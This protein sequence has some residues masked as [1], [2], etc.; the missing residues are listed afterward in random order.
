MFFDAVISRRLIA[1]LAVFGV[2]AIVVYNLHPADVVQSVIYE[3]LGT[4]AVVSVTLRARRSLGSERLGLMIVAAGIGCWVSGDLLTDVLQY[5]SGSATVSY[6]SVADIPYTL[7]YGVIL[8][9]AVV[10]ARNVLKRPWT[11]AFVDAAI[12][13]STFVVIGWAAINA[14]GASAGSTAASLGVLV[15]PTLDVLVLAAGVRLF[16][17][18]W[19]K[20]PLVLVWCGLAA[21]LVADTGY[22]MSSLSYTVGGAL[23][24]GWLLGYLGFAVAAQCPTGAAP[25]ATV[26]QL[27]LRPG[28]LV[29]VGLALIATSV[30]GEI[31]AYAVNDMVELVFTAA[32]SAVLATL[33]MVRM[34]IV[35]RAHDRVREREQQALNRFTAI[36]EHAGLAMALM[37]AERNVT[38]VNAGALKLFGYASGESCDRQ[39]RHHATRDVGT[40]TTM[41]SPSSSPG[42]VTDTNREAVCPR[43]RERLPRPSHVLACAR[44]RDGSMAFAIAIIEDVTEIRAAEAAVRQQTAARPDVRRC[45]IAMAV[46]DGRGRWVRAKRRLCT[47]LGYERAGAL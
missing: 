1:V 28:R 32:T 34:A 17:A 42:S 38:G 26:E 33:V 24:N 16:G 36:F 46:T 21:M 29:A 30:A 11:L 5:T 47:L 39:C 19:R 41:R 23:D 6:P 4:V 27:R 43:G 44:V 10:L 45:R 40:R 22:A 20:L 13:A 14:A 37:S 25:S 31:S 18:M 3:G 9:G 35:L 12:A 7:G 2:A 15:Y 8:A